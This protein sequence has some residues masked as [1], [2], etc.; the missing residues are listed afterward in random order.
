M[1]F[2]YYPVK[3]ILV[4]MLFK[5]PLAF[6][7]F[8]SPI[9]GAV[10]IRPMIGSR[11]RA[12]IEMKRLQKVGLFSLESDSFLA[13]KP[14]DQ[15]FY[16]F[17]IPLGEP[18]TVS[19][20]GYDQTFGHAS[21]HMLSPGMPFTFKCKKKCNV[22]VANFFVDSMV[23]YRERM[24]QETTASGQ[25]IGPHVSLMSLAG[26]GLYRSVVRA[27][28]ALGM[29]DCAVNDVAV[30]ELEDD[31]LVRFMLLV[32]NPPATTKRAEFPSNQALNNIED[33]ICANLDAAIT[34]DDLAE[35]AGMPIRSLSRAFEK[36]YG[37]GPMAFVR[38]RRLDACFV[39]LRGSDREIT[40]VTEVA[41]SFGFWHIGK[42]AIA[43]RET[44]GESPS[45]S[46][47][48]KRKTC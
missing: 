17:S 38:Q 40:T 47:L 6:E 32:E 22:L 12:N 3:S 5:D 48:K 8:L 18:F 25:F 24:L 26:S 30:Q 4:R 23:T 27:W 37:L 43:Y 28:V 39:Q 33:Y 31:L 29:E 13:E 42:F 15:D 21:A 44:F 10:K 11:F 35:K 46:L 19:S 9:G 1:V 14:P 2:L 34:R 41:M 45:E 7:E 20:P 36:N 16:G